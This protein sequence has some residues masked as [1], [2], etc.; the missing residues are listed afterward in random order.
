MIEEQ[1]I[2][3]AAPA[4]TRS[5]EGDAALRVEHLS[6]D[7]RL[8]TNILH[9]VRD[10]SFVLR[11]GK[12]L[13]LVGESGSGKSVTARALL[14]IVDKNGAITGGRVL[15]RDGDGETDIV[16]LTERSPEL[17][18]I[19]GGRIGLI[20]QEPMSSLSPVHTIGS[21]IVEAVRLHQ[22]MDRH[23]ARRGAP[24]SCC[25]RSRFPIPTS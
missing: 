18:R 25:A 24:S 11:Q 5:G 20:F 2:A 22:R 17:L 12:T 13:C 21:Q 10:V 6:L 14:R 7:F 19:R 4:D 8:R 16:P 3:R 23:A 9:A 15:L 1:I